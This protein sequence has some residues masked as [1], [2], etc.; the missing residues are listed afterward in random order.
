ME[1]EWSGA[2]LEPPGTEHALAVVVAFISMQQAS[3][4]VAHVHCVCQTLSWLQLL[5]LQASC[6]PVEIRELNAVVLHGAA[7][8]LLCRVFDPTAHRSAAAK[9]AAGDDRVRPLDRLRSGGL[10]TAPGVCRL[11]VCG[12]KGMGAIEVRPAQCKVVL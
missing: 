12:G 1:A 7:V 11:H 8:L 4:E 6:K 10:P 5:F 2:V 9:P 3:G